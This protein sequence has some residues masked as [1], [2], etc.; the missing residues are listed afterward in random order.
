MPNF[1]ILSF[2]GGGI[3]G[4]LT[5]VLVNRLLGEYP[6]LLQDRPD[7][8]TMFAGTSTGGILALG[9]AAGLTPA[10]IRDLYVTNG[11]LIFDS[12]WTRDVVEIG[13]L[14]GAKY[15]NANLKQILRE[16]FGA[17]KLKDLKPRVLIASFSLDNQ[18]PDPSSRT[19]NPKFF[20][21]FSGT[22][23]DGES[24][25]VDVAMST[26]AA[27]TYFPSYG[28]YVDGGVIA[29]NPSMA[30]VVQALDGRNQAGERATLE[31]IKLLSVGTGASLEYIEGQDHDW[32]DAQWIKPILNVMMDGGVGVADF[33]CAQ[34]LGNRYCRI[35]PVFPA[36]K[37]FPMDDV[38]KIVDL[39]D[40]AQS[41]DLTG[42]VAWL[43]SSGW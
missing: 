27:P 11:K 42:A 25:L 23:S 33:E 31:G 10:Q 5:A 22:D 29:N 3:R 20:H 26:S 28:V 41:F 15:D 16:T 24:L 32:G 14:S 19:W 38:S 17:L 9:M 6:T 4:V 35:E 2:D 37:S 43:K 7:T 39:M 21:N 1:R 8:I 34:L 36:G 12:S 40:L 30:A 18:A 13:G